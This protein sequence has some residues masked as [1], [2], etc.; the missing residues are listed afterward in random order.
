MDGTVLNIVEYVHWCM[1]VLVF[2]DG[3]LG[4]AFYKGIDYTN[5]QF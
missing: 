1:Y 4:V 5:V 3:N 2:V